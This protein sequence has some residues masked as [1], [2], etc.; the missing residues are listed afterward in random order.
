MPSKRTSLT[1]PEDLLKEI[2]FICSALSV[3]RSALISEL[4][5]TGI[6]PLTEV[7]KQAFPDGVSADTLRKRDPEVIRNH[8]LAMTENAYLDA[9]SDI[10]KFEFDGGKN[11]SH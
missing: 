11:G 2:D 7:L 9:R 6:G 3:S 4:L 8:L 10:E 5:R 1:L